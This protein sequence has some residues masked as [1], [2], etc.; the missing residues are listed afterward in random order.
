MAEEEEHHEVWQVIALDNELA[1][2]EQLQRE[3]TSLRQR[4]TEG[5][6]DV[7]FLV[8]S[9]GLEPPWQ[10]QAHGLAARTTAVDEPPFLGHLKAAGWPSLVRFANAARRTLRLVDPGARRSVRP[11]HATDAQRSQGIAPVHTPPDQPRLRLVDRASASTVARE[12]IEALLA[13]RA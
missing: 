9:D 8:H 4:P 12:E 10:S 7:Q 3:S 11:G 1:H 5:A 2:D 6:V 13:R